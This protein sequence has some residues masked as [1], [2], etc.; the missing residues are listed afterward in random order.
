LHNTTPQTQ[1]TTQNPCPRL[2]PAASFSSAC[3]PWRP[4]LL[5]T[6]PPGNGPQACP[7]L[8]PTLAAQTLTTPAPQP[9]SRL[10]L[11]LL[12]AGGRLQKK[13]LQAL[14]PQARAAEATRAV[15]RNCFLARL[16]PSVLQR[17]PGR[18]SIIESVR[19]ALLARRALVERHVAHF[20]G[21][22]RSAFAAMSL[23]LRPGTVRT[24]ASTF[25]AANPQHRRQIAPYTRFARRALLTRS[26]RPVGATPV[27]P[28]ALKDL[29]PR[30]AEDL[31]NTIA[32]MWVSASRAIDLQ[33]F[34]AELVG[35]FWRISLFC[36]DERGGLVPPKSD[37]AAT[38]L[39]TKWLPNVPGLNL[40]PPRW[41]TWAEIRAALRPLK[42]ATPHS[43]RVSAVR[44]LE[45]SGFSTAEIATLTGHAPGNAGVSNYVARVAAD[46]AAL[47]S[48][49][50]SRLLAAKLL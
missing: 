32:V 6:A 15:R 1:S 40:Q 50:L 47:M 45:S 3:P 30:I 27:T 29:R 22:F 36:R 39:I 10:R 13:A 35:G 24:Y 7:R 31:W 19:P 49:R 12:S 33:H 42:G 25:A 23:V 14:F 34:S 48:L 46:P 17:I 16:T 8:F 37:Q 5:S 2:F 41:H 21:D 4:Q 38:R 18:I 43:I 44:F 20:N 26:G 28:E 11:S 9:K